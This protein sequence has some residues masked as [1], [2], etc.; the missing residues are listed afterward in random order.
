M[1]SSRFAKVLKVGG[2]AIFLQVVILSGY[3]SFIHFRFSDVLG[4]YM[5][6]R[7][8]YLSFVIFKVVVALLFFKFQNLTKIL[9]FLVSQ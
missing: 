1:M 7:Q 5:D 4:A 9:R 2:C 8:L 6:K 3:G